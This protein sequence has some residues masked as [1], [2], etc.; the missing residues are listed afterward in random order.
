MIYKERQITFDLCNHQLSNINV[1]T[2]DSQW[3]VYD[4]RPDGGSFTSKTIEKIHVN[5]REVTQIYQ[6]NSDAHVGVVTVSPNNPP[7]MLL[8]TVL[9]IQI[10]LGSMIFIIA[11][12]CM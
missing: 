8:F 11:A 9:K 12:V 6:A 3:L 4:L 7:V 10:N 1:W 2:P 5:T